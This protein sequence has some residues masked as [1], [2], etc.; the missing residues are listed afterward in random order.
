MSVDG[1]DHNGRHVVGIAL[2]PAKAKK[3]LGPKLIEKAA[4]MGIEIRPVH[5]GRPL[6]EQGPFDVLLHKVRR[7]EWEEELVRY[8]A[9][10]PSM[11]IIDSMEAIR[12]I[13]SRLSML[14]PFGD[15]GIHL[16][17]PPG[18][19]DR[20]GDEI[21]VAAPQQISISEDCSRE[22]AKRLLCQANMK[23]PLLA[24]PLWADG[25]DGAH[26]LAVIHEVDGV[27]QLVSGEGPSD[28]RLPATL[29]QYVEHGGC[30]FKV[31]VMGPIV[32]MARRPSLN[33]PVPP[34]DVQ[35]EL[36]HIQTIA[37]IS[38]FQSE[39]AGTAVLQGDPPQ[40]MV[41]GLAQELRKR[42]RLNLFNFD[43]LRP[44]A[45]QPGRVPRDA[46]YMVIDINY[47]PGFEKLPNYETM[48]VDFL[49]TLLHKRREA[50]PALKK[51]M[52][53]SQKPVSRGSS[54]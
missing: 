11:R 14:A 30:L 21:S 15:H 42:L 3:H 16:K 35:D 52:S 39:M 8:S 34:E 49:S 24:K 28:F 40:W 29:Q 43:L 17:R 27:E 10:H 44:S 50:P 37:R 47:F 54:A 2:L 12:P 6:E 45:N 46:D 22:E 41:Q 1:R 5:V 26:G 32:V 4:E 13:M 38:S 18:G 25:R 48:M 53:F 36:G 9:K 7:K 20:E 23:P 31:F 51:L 19:D 33:I